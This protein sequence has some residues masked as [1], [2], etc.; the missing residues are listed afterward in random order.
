MDEREFYNN[1]KMKIS[2]IIEMAHGRQLWIYGAGIGGG[3]V[4]EVFKELD[5]EFDGFIDKRADEIK[6]IYRHCVVTLS[7]VDPS[8]SYIVL[9]LREYDTEAVES[10]RRAGFDDKSFYVLAAGTGYNKEDIIYKGCQIGRYSYGY[11]GLLEYY[12]MAKSIGRYCSING[13]AKIMNNHPLECISTHPFLDHP[14]FMDWE[15]YL[16]RKELL[17]KYGKYLDNDK[18]EDSLIRKNRSVVVGNDV[19]IGANA[20]ILPGVTIGD[21]AVVAAGAIVTKNVAPYAIV[22]G[23]PAKVIKMRFNEKTVAQLESIRW[24]EWEHEDIEN[25]IELFFNIESFVSGYKSRRKMKK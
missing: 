9:S 3:I 22:G 6:S 1:C 21:G 18:F 7:S 25:N 16:D 24:W 14:F 10:I 19:W 2:T 4:S 23:N 5:I 17:K 20:I 13:S 11:E 8:M 12:P 15:E